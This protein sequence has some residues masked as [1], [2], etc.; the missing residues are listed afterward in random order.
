[1]LHSDKMKR[2]VLMARLEQDKAE[3]K[4]VVSSAYEGV[5]NVVYA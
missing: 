5:E 1:M 4:Q 2:T 3:G